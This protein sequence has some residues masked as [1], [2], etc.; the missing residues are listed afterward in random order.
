MSGGNPYR[1][2]VELSVNG[3]AR[4]MRLSL[5][6]LAKLEARL[7]SGSLV[8]MVSRF[9]EG[10]FRTADLVALISAG[11]DMAEEDVLKAEF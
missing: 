6:A 11:L 8:A 9:E 5:G 7:E 10:A 2:E 1:G 4:V 3:E